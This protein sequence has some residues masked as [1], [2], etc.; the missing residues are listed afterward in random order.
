MASAVRHTI[1]IAPNSA[2]FDLPIHI[3]LRDGLFASRGLDVAF[4]TPQDADISSA[5]AF[6][7]QKGRLFESGGA[8]AYNLCEW[9]GL[10]RS[11]GGCR[12]SVVA[13]LR[14]AVAAQALLTFDTALREPRDLAHVPVAINDRTGSHCTALQLLEGA[15]ARDEI[16]LRHV[17]SPLARYRALKSGEVRVAMLMEPYV[18]LLLREGAR[19]LGSIFYRG[20]QVVSPDLHPADVA[21]YTD[22]LDEAVVAI[23]A[24]FLSAKRFIVEPVAGLLRPEQMFDHF[25]HYAPSRAMD[26]RRSAFTCDG[27]K[28]WGLAEDDGAFEKLVAAPQV[29]AAPTRPAAHGHRPGDPMPNLARRPLLASLAASALAPHAA[30]AQAQPPVRGGTLIYLEQRAA[31]V[32]AARAKSPYFRSLARDADALEHRTRT[33]K[34]IFLNPDGGLP[35]A[36]RELAA[37]VASRVNGCIYGASVHARLAAIYSRREAD[38]DRLLAEGPGAPLGGRWE[39]IAEAATALTATPAG[40]G[41]VHVARLRAAGLDDLAILDLVQAAAF[42]GWANR[43]MLSLGEAVEPAEGRGT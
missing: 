37:A 8:V 18:S 32:D 40:F 9:A 43:L 42:F 38:V 34:D 24:D 36:E 27:R 7:R 4:T 22:A 1:R 11:E 26:E 3:A 33:D 20:A 2:V 17:G 15:L 19:L 21:A 23:N 29:W 35:R 25:V 16:V 41:A 12:S 5:D 31:L 10:D 13:S 28:S 6:A 30:S 39:A 14:P